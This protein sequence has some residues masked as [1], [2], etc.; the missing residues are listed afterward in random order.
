MFD[1]EIDAD[2][3]Y[4]RRQRVEK[5]RGARA[6]VD[7]DVCVWGETAEETEIRSRP[8]GPAIEAPQIAER[9][10]HV[11]ARRVVLVQQLLGDDAFHGT[12]TKVVRQT[13][14]S[15]FNCAIGFF[16]SSKTS[17]T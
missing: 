17:I 14:T 4:I 13:G 3:H 2:R 10:L 1:I 6:E 11:V 7:D 9:A 8:A 12:S 16:A 5:I 15:T